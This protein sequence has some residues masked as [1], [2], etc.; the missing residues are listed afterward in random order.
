[1]IAASQ[2]TPSPI[3][4]RCHMPRNIAS[5]CSTNS[6]MVAAFSNRARI[7]AAGQ[8]SSKPALRNEQDIAGLDIHVGRD[9]TAPDEILQPHA[10]LLASL[11]GAH[12]G[13]VV[14]VREISQPAHGDHQV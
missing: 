10:V 2:A 8:W 6:C 11:G 7:Y 12:D 14:A 13:R 9:V 3:Q 4:R 1:M 5:S